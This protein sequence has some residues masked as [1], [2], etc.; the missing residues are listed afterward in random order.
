VAVLLTLVMTRARKVAGTAAAVTLAYVLVWFSALKVPL[1]DQKL[2]DEILPVIPWWLLV[3]FGS[4]SLWLLGKGLATFRQCDDAYE[5]LLRDISSA[6]M[7]L[8]SRG[9][10]VD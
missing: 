10:V 7:D 6:K 3:S 5:E 9:V 2:V 1:V 4:Y 8:R